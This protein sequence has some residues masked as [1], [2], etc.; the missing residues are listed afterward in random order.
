[1]L[2]NTSTSS[3]R[4]VLKTFV[5]RFVNQ[6]LFLDII[7]IS[8]YPA[9]FNDTAELK[10]VNYINEFLA[11]GI[12][13]ARQIGLPNHKQ[14]K[15]QAEA[16]ASILTIRD[17]KTVI[18]NYEN[19]FQHINIQDLSVKTLVEKAKETKIDSV[20]DFKNLTTQILNIIQSYYE[21]TT[22][23]SNIMTYDLL[24]EKANTLDIPPFEFLARYNDV[25]IQLYNDLS[26]LKTL[27]KEQSNLN[28]YFIIN[29]QESS[30]AL[31]KDLTRYFSEGYVFYKTGYDFLDRN[32]QGFESSSVHIISAASNHGKSLLMINLCQNILNYNQDEFQPGDAILFV[33]LEDNIYKLSRRFISIFG[34]Y[35]NE[36]VVKLYKRCYEV[37]KEFEG[38]KAV[39]QKITNL[40]DGI[41]KK[42]LVKRTSD[43]VSLIIYHGDENTFSPGDLSRFIDTQKRNGYNIKVVFVDYVDVM[44][45]TL[46]NN[47]TSSN[48]YFS[49]GQIVQE[50][51][52]TARRYNIPIITATQNSK[53]GEDETKSLNNMIIGDSYKKVRYTDYLYMGKMCKAKTILDPAVKKCV[54]KEDKNDSTQPTFDLIKMQNKLCKVLIPYEFKI[55]KSKEGGRDEYTYLLFCNENLKM[56][57]TI[58]DYLND[59]PMIQNNTKQ[60]VRE[61][62]NL[63]I[64]QSSLSFEDDIF[65]TVLSKSGENLEEM[66]EDFALI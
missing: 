3:Q 34:D 5:S 57:E 35:V 2:N 49:Q 56:Y 21:F 31:S 39:Q 43:N 24:I 40:I 8:L 33:T 28:N 16:V 25:T 62:D 46:S 58:Q 38:D 19:V 37:C 64:S 63:S 44:T 52:N 32:I 53:V 50:L 66:E 59:A 26:K 6:D 23:Q 18:I 30:K 4:S 45:P 15:T 29:S 1:M 12:K 47:L 48:E 20:D 51:R 11:H 22:I 42:S 17:S 41:L 36:D 27:T 55:T 14:I 9:E 10:V 13:H 65:Q 61:M 54:S 7:R 60:L